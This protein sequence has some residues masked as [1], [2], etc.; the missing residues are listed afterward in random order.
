MS[1]KTI[2]I[3]EES[4]GDLIKQSHDL[5]D[6]AHPNQLILFEAQ[7]KAVCKFYACFD[8]HD[9]QYPDCDYKPNPCQLA[10]LQELLRFINQ[11]ENCQEK[12]KS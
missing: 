6:K 5:L 11:E 8:S 1:E 2:N 4:L 7:K 9:R 3:P 12:E 10:R